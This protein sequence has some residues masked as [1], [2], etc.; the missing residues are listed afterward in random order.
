MWQIAL[1]LTANV[2][3]LLLLLFGYSSI[4]IFFLFCS[5]L[6]SIGVSLHLFYMSTSQDEYVDLIA[7]KS[8]ERKLND[9]EKI[10]NNV[11]Y[12]P[13]KVVIDGVLKVYGLVL[14]VKRHYADIVTMRDGQI[15]KRYFF[16]TPLVIFIM[17]MFN[18]S[19]TVVLWLI[20]NWLILRKVIR[21]AL[22]DDSIPG[23]EEEPKESVGFVTKIKTMLTKLTAGK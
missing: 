23:V 7:Q 6:L 12:V 14:S 4:S 11:E 19:D 17:Y 10:L 20:L 16:F 1:L 8:K 21:D 2:F 22:A 5:F 3:C 18:I 15:T 9:K 13:P